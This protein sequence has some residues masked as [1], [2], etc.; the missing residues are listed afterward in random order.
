MTTCES[1]YYQSQASAPFQN[2]RRKVELL[3]E[4]KIDSLLIKKA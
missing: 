3:K 4:M 2:V 1:Y